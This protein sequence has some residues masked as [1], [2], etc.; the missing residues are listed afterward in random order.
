MY[1]VIFSPDAQKDLISLKKKAP[2]AFK[3]F[4][5][6][7]EEL[8]QHPKTGTG[9]CEQLNIMVKRHSLVASTRSIG[10]YIECTM[11]SLKSLSY[12]PLDIIK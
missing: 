7:Y 10:W 11:M 3:K 5:K 8:K 6:I 2:V 12:L 4:L 9:Q 1:N